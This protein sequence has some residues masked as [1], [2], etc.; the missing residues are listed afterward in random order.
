MNGKS[1]AIPMDYAEWL[2]AIK[3]R[4]ATA[5][6]RAALAAN[7][8]LIQ[9]YWQIGRDILQRQSTQGWGSKVI[10]RLARDLREAFPEMKGFSA[11]NLKYMRAFAE[12]WPD[13]EFVQQPAAQ[14]PWFHLC[15]LIDKLKDPALR[16]YYADLARTEGW[17]RVTL[18]LNIRNRLHERQGQAVTNFDAR[19][20]APH[21]EL[22]HETL[23]DPYL[24]DFLGLGDEAQER[25]IENALVRHIIKFLLELGNGFAFVGR[26]FRLEVEGDEFFADLL[27]YHTRLKCYVVVELKATAFKPE[28]AGQLNFYLTTVDKQ[29][30]AP[31][32]KPTIGLLLCKT[33]KRTVAEYALSGIDKPIGVAEY[34]L[35]RA[36]PE[37]LVTSLP[38]VEELESELSAVDEEQPEG[39]DE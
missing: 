7:A 27:F 30:K 25:E 33:K 37:P 10:E 19:L 4:V 24:F 1:A 17:S 9:L 6:Q 18:E 15:T 29:V 8:E 20:P 23:K 12:A 31:D 38:T 2:A 11:R 32:D 35:V 34:Q 39:S 21:S 36:L 26:Q 3:A 28:H 5:R 22:A 16:L 14:L 13:A